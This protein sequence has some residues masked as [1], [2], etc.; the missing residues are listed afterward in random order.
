VLAA[1][2]QVSVDRAFSMLR[3]YA[4]DRYATLRAVTDALVRRALRP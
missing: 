3:M 2:S 1:E 4:N